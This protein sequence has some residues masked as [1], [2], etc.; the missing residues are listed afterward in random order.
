MKAW[1]TVT[2]S[3]QEDGAQLSYL[4]I[5]VL[6]II[7]SPECRLYWATP[8]EWGRGNGMSLPRWG[9]KTVA[10]ILGTLLHSLLD[11]LIWGKPTARLL[12]P[13]C[14][15]AHV[16]CWHLCGWTWKQIPG[17]HSLPPPFRWDC[18]WSFTLAWANGLTIILGGA[19]SQRHPSKVCPDSYSWN[20][21]IVS[22]CYFKPL[23]FRVICYREIDN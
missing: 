23:S 5:H 21:E 9:Y 4:G 10:F 8:A 15:G 18:S 17:T 14:A 12:K 20:C 7:L 2:G 19:L 22:F 16:A 13:S 6:I 1:V 3:V 11:D